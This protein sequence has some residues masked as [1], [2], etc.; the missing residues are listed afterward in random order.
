MIELSIYQEKFSF[1]SQKPQIPNPGEGTSS[2]TAGGPER[3]PQRATSFHFTVSFCNHLGNEVFKLKFSRKKN[4][5]EEKQGADI[6]I[7]EVA[8]S[9]RRWWLPAQQVVLPGTQSPASQ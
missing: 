4:V 6:T 5:F 3:S 1:S 9:V 7:L 8:V 2:I